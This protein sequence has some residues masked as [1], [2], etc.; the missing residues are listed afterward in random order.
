MGVITITD[1]SG[2]REVLQPELAVVAKFSKSRVNS[3]HQPNPSSKM[4]TILDKVAG[5]YTGQVVFFKS[6]ESGKR[7]WQLPR[8]V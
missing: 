2:D 5:T 6:N 4:N 3:R 1:A 8:S 7:A